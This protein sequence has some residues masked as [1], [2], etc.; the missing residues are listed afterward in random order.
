MSEPFIERTEKQLSCFSEFP[1]IIAGLTTRR[2]GYSSAPYQTL[3]MGLHVGDD[4]S[5]VV[6][7]RLAL[8]DELEINLDRWVV[9]EQV[10]D[11]LVKKVTEQDSGSGSES[12]HTVVKGIDGFITNEKDLLLTAFYADCVPLFFYDPES[13]W[14]GIAHAGWK[15]TVK[16]MAG[17]MIDHL[18]DQGV[19]KEN[20]R[21]VIGPSIGLNEY[22]VD[23]RVYE[24]IPKQHRSAVTRPSGVDR[25]FVDLKE[26]NSRMAQEHGLDQK[27]IQRS[28]LCTY[29]EEQLLFS[30]RRD[31]GQTGRML[32]Y[33]AIKGTASGGM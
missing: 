13:G 10:H 28:G 9:G 6:R 20:L 2:G 29:E 14:I 16:G 3:N 15:G 19:S 33:I 17:V 24:K 21:M 4:P 1:E 18:I 25:Y 31:G 23:M 27:Q 8:A 26:L 11:V 30:H 5:D 32:G 12:L 22:E 7:N